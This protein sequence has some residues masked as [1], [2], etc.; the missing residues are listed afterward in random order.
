MYMLGADFIG[1]SYT[2]LLLHASVRHNRMDGVLFWKDNMSWIQIWLHLHVL[3]FRNW[4][5]VYLIQSHKYIIFTS[6]SIFWSQLLFFRYLICLQSTL[7]RCNCTFRQS[8]L[9]YA[10]LLAE[11]C[12]PSNHQSVRLFYSLIPPYLTP[13]AADSQK[14]PLM[15]ISYD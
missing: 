1:I 5:L 3:L 2:R 6:N 7:R 10:I 13:F 8:C 15:M 4:W 12:L 14:D 11:L 9:L